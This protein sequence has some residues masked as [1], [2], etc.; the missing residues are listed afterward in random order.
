M[1]SSIL[2][3][4]GGEVGRFLARLLSGWGHPTVIVEMRADTARQLRDTGM[5]VVEGDATDP[6]TLEAASIGQF[7]TV[8]AV[9]GSDEVNLTVSALARFEFSVA[10]TVARVN[11]PRQAWM[12]CPEVGVDWAV[13]QAEVLANLI[14]EQTT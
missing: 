2:I 8:A 10:R 14:V 13:N 9:T 11:L 12:F 4:G 5:K 1:K 3:V 6:E 7:H